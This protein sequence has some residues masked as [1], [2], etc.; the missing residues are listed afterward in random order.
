[1]SSA[2]PQELRFRRLIISGVTLELESNKLIVWHEIISQNN[3]DSTLLENTE[4]AWFEERK[5]N[6]PAEWNDS[7]TVHMIQQ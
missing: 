7:T 6:E 5:I 3:L 2:F 1:M 4:I